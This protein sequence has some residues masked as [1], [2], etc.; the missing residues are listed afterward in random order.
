MTVFAW[1]FLIALDT[2]ET[3]SR[4]YDTRDECVARI[5]V[6]ARSQG[7]TEAW[8]VEVPWRKA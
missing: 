2:G 6:A 5:R 4:T 8:C 3:F 1:V 7:V